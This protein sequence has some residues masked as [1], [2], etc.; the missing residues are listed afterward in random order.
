MVRMSVHR[1][2]VPERKPIKNIPLGHRVGGGEMVCVRREETGGAGVD[3][4]VIN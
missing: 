4:F 3:F 1:I 2:P